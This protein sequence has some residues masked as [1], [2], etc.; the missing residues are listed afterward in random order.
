MKTCVMC[1][2]SATHYCPQ[3]DAFLCSGCNTTIHSANLLASRHKVL[4]IN[5]FLQQGGKAADAQSEASASPAAVKEETCILSP[6]E[7][8]TGT[9]GVVPVMATNSTM[10]DGTA[11]AAAAASSDQQQGAKWGSD[12]DLFDLDAGWLDKLDCGFDLGGMFDEA[13]LVPE[14]LSDAHGVVPD[15]SA[16][17][18]GEVP[19]LPSAASGP[20]MEVPFLPEVSESLPEHPAKRARLE[21][22]SSSDD[23]DLLVP[24]SF[25]VPSFDLPCL[26]DAF[27][28]APPATLFHSSTQPAAASSAAAPAYQMPAP[29]VRVSAEQA[30]INRAERLNLYREKK[31]NRKFEKTIRYASRKAYAEVRPRIKG[32]FATPAEVAAMKAAAEAA[33]AGAALDDDDAVVPC[34]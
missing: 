12:F 7:S 17:A 28:A 30:A 5:E 31:K 13:Q 22:A 2:A 23:G 29:V 8:L 34:M 27:D 20:S 1:A 18:L 19:F 9:E 10:L 6:P 16:A 15:A 4:A 3:D 24:S 21:A 14:F 11:P 26:D 25:A 33:K 32:R